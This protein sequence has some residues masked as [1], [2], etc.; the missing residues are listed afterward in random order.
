MT[1]S[2][3]YYIT[4]VTTE[5]PTP[6]KTVTGSGHRARH[7]TKPRKL[8]VTTYKSSYLDE[9]VKNEGAC[10]NVWYQLIVSDVARYP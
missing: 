4:L 3:H 7:V 5:P 10:L 2:F 8:R 6:R 9:I 1:N